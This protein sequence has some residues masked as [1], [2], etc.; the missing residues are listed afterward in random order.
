MLP[1][2]YFSGGSVKGVWQRVNERL[3]EQSAAR[4]LSFAYPEHLRPYCDLVRAMGTRS[5]VM[6][7]SGAYTTWRQGKR[8]DLDDLSSTFAALLDHY[9]DCCDFVLINL[10]VIPGSVGID[11]D[12]DELDDAMLE[13]QRN[14][15]ALNRRFPKLVLPVFHQDEPLSYFRALVQ[16]SPY[17]C[18][19][20][21]NDMGERRRVK[22]AQKFGDRAPM[23][24][25]HGLAATGF[26]MTRQVE[27]HSVD[28]AAW[29]RTAAVGNIFW[30]S[31]KRLLKLAVSPRSPALKNF[32]LHIDH[33]K[34][35]VKRKVID[36]IEAKGYTLDALKNEDTSRYMLNA[37]CWLEAR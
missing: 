2:I 36:A 28:S 10:D 3:I 24:R 34:A 32:D 21:R 5:R 9:G 15:E 25:F 6:V 22:W 16:E 19:S 26:H 1:L 17:I 35:A 12:P 23:C 11:A 4:L 8:T 31:T 29:V 27:W 18:L 13:S 20:P 14:F 7:D 30:P 33:L 37:Q